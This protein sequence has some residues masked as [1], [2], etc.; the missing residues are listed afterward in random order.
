[1]QRR[2]VTVAADFAPAG[3]T[4]DVTTKFRHE[5]VAGMDVQW[6]DAPSTDAILAAYF[7][8][9]WASQRKAV[10]FHRP[11]PRTLTWASTL[12]TQ[13]RPQALLKNFARIANHI[14]A[15]WRDPAVLNRYLESLLVDYRGGR[16]GFPTEVVRELQTLKSYYSLGVLPYVSSGR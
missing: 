10:P 5:R 6:L 8:R 12:P 2:Q 3:R 11:L 4:M 9:T 15:S 14:A 1:M 13:F 7:D 16:R